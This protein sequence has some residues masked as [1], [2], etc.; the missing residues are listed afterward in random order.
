MTLQGGVFELPPVERE[1]VAAALAAFVPSD[2]NGYA[3]DDMVVALRSGESLD[4]SSFFG[5][6]SGEAQIPACT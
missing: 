2:P 1:R 5:L 4:P 3:P 6:L